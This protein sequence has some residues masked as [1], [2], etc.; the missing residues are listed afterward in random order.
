MVR[1][2]GLF[3]RWDEPALSVRARNRLPARLPQARS[4][5]LGGDRGLRQRIFTAGCRASLVCRSTARRDLLATTRSAL[6]RGPRLVAI[7][8]HGGGLVLGP[9]ERRRD[10]LG[11]SLAGSDETANQP[12][13][14]GGA[15][16]RV[17]RVRGGHQTRGRSRIAGLGYF[18]HLAGPRTGT[19]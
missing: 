1:R 15:A 4:D 18:R 5:G 2:R 3:E 12:V 8:R 14:S 13:P 17:G 9:L 19:T 16:R 6:R 7:Q 11:R 10:R